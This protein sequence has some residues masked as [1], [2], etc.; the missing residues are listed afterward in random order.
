MRQKY[1]GGSPRIGRCR[2]TVLHGF[3][4]KGATAGFNGGADGMSAMPRMGKLDTPASEKGL[5]SVSV[6]AA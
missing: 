1:R 3:S 6:P 4:V 2:Q 5:I